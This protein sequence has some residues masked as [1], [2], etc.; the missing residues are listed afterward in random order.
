MRSFLS[1]LIAICAISSSITA[2]L[3]SVHWKTIKTGL[4]SISYPKKDWV[5][6]VDSIMGAQFV[7]AT[8]NTIKKP[9]DRD[10]VQFRI[11]ENEDNLYGDLDTYTENIKNQLGKDGGSVLSAERV[12]KGNLEYHEQVYKNYQGK[13]KRKIKERQFF[14]NQKVYQLSFDAAET[15]FNKKIVQVDSI[16]NS[17]TIEDLEA[18]SA[19]KWETFDTPQYSFTYPSNWKMDKTL[20]PNTEFILKKPKKS[21]DKGYWDNIYLMVNTLSNPDLAT[22]TKKATEQLK[23]TLKNVKIEQSIKKKLGKISYQEVIS[24]GDLGKNRVKMRQWHFIKGKK[25]YTL[26]YSAREESFNDLYPIVEQ[27]SNSF[28]LK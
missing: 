2:Q 21:S 23:T 3:D 27:I 6:Y 11:M 18:I 5:M 4:Y 8:I 7:I 12:K 9:Y 19:K 28:S 16:F 10:I 13:I 20:P 1:I 26:T 22:F 14:I 15:V 25:A 24:V 17:L